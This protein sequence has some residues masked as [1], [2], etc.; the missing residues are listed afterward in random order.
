MNAKDLTTPIFPQERRPPARGT[1]LAFDFGEK[2]I[3]VA[4]GELE[5]ATA[6]PLAEI[7]TEAN[8]VR[9]TR[10]AEL[11]TEWQPALMVVGLPLHI[12]G[13]E[14]ELTRLA[15]RFARRL[16]G[17]F[18]IPVTL[19][20]E[21]YSSLD[22]EASLREISVSTRNKK[23]LIDQVAALRILQTYLESSRT[24]VPI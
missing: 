22:A 21:R 17:R 15:R 12:D 1:V 5:S 19:C 8:E 7:D 10:I 16:Q 14:H 4:V 13:T 3:G 20:D 23:G 9:F 18:G 11:C 24:Y 2:R 6:H